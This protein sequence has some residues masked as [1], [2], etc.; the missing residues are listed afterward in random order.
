M[1]TKLKHRCIKTRD[2][3]VSFTDKS[4]KKY[5]LDY[6]FLSEVSRRHDVNLVMIVQPPIVGAVG[7]SGTDSEQYCQY[8]LN[9]IEECKYP[10]HST[11]EQY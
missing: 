11:R 6:H 10:D 8:A 7:S 2:I 9:R 4:M 3:V 5:I 1:I